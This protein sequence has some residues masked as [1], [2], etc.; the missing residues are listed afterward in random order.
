LHER[1]LQFTVQIG[2]ALTRIAL[3]NELR[4]IIER[5][6]LLLLIAGAPSKSKQRAQSVTTSALTTS[7]RR[8]GPGLGIR[9][10]PSPNGSVSLATRNASHILHMM[11]HFFDSQFDSQADELRCSVWTLE[12]SRD[13]GNVEF[14]A[15]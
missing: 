9:D 2:C 14:A 8:R 12:K 4:V 7:A 1:M 10:D 11:C 6:S 15:C 13:P 5:V 3:V